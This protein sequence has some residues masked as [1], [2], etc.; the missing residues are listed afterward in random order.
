MLKKYKLMFESTEDIK[1]EDMDDIENE[2]LEELTKKLVS[3]F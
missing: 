2:D 3:K 1:I